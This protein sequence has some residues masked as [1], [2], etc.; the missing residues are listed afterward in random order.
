MSRLK[1]F[2]EKLKQRTK[3]QLFKSLF[4]A[5][6]TTVV[7]VVFVVVIIP[8]SPKASFDSIKAFS[9]EIIYQVSVNDEDNAIQGSSIKVI[10]E[11]QL[12]KEVNYIDVGQSMG[13]FTGLNPNTLY[14]LQVVFDKGFGDEVLAKTEVYTEAAFTAAFSGY[15]LLE[16]GETSYLNYLVNIKYSDEF[17][18]DT[19][20]VRYGLLY[21]S[22]EEI[23]I[24]QTIAISPMQTEFLLEDIL[25]YQ[26]ILV[27]ILE[28]EDNG[29]FIPLDEVRIVLPF[30][31]HSSMYLA[32]YNDHQAAF[33]LYFD[34]EL[35]SATYWLETRLNDYLI[36][37]TEVKQ[38]GFDH[39][40]SLHLVE[41]LLPE[42]DYV[43]QLYARYFDPITLQTKETIFSE[44][45][46]TTLEAF[47]YNYEI[48]EYDNYYQV[49]ISTNTDVFDQGFYDVYYIEE[50]ISY[51]YSGSVFDFIQVDDNY[52]VSFRIDKQSFTDYYIEFG[53]RSSSE[54]YYRIKI[55]RIEGK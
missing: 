46:L 40:S 13:S 4:Q 30:T 17:N 54:Y 37:K 19:V 38:T 10:L 42:R 25:S 55:E 29:V 27:V 43:F 8:N 11:N 26:A 39:H 5:L 50:E 9:D 53:I 47:T 3:F 35:P 1:A 21:P 6:S 49:T 34:Y 51:Y 31:I 36:D 44:V 52:S 12:T 33:H 28:V 45:S 41:N 24:F 2:Q 18:Y 16:T 20:R 32:Y 48:I 14:N 22:S 23:E 15:N 7:T